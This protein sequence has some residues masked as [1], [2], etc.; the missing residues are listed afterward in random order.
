LVAPEPDPEK[1]LKKGKVLQGASSSKCSS[2][3][4]DLP[5]YYFHTPI[6]VTYVSHFSIAETPIKSKLG[7]FPVEYSTFSPELK[8]ESLENFDFLTSAEIV[9]W[10]RL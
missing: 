8:E 6:F 5:E 9:K 7:D 1:I 3:Y 4:G 10:S 2:T